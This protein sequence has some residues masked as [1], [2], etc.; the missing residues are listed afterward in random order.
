MS[1]ASRLLLAAATLATSLILP[2]CSTGLTEPTAVPDP[3]L[4][5]RDT[6]S[7]DNISSS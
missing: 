2:R 4:D 5:G 1:Q 7:D 3:N 6:G